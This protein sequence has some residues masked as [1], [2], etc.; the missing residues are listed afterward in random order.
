MLKRGRGSNGGNRS[1]V[2]SFVPGAN[3]SLWHSAQLSV[4][5]NSEAD[6]NFSL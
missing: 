6:D 1:L 4:L 2:K 3:D 5:L